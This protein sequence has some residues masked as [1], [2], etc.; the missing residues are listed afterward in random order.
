MK[1]KGGNYDLCKQYFDERI[2]HSDNDK[3]G[4]LLFRTFT[5][6]QRILFIN[7]TI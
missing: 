6:H 3:T 4:I 7:K 5:T 2:I 1:K